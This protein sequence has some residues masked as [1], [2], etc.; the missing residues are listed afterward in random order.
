MATIFAEI[1]LGILA[2]IIVAW[3]SRRREYR[4]DEVGSPIGGEQ[5]NDRRTATSKN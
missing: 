2:S 1:I 3:F 4:A 5:R